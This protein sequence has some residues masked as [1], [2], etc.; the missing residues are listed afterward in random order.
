MPHSHQP[1][2]GPTQPVLSDLLAG[3]LRQ[4]ISRQAAGLASAANTGEV[5]PF[6]AATSQ[7]VDAKAAWSAA[8]AV[9]HYYHPAGKTQIWK[10]PA[11]WPALVSAQEPVAALAFSFGNYPQQVRDFHALLHAA[12]LTTLRP[13]GTG[14][15]VHVQFGKGAALGGNQQ[16]YPQALLNAGVVRLARQFEEAAELL[17][18]LQANIP[19]GWQAAWANEEAALAWHR[20]QAQE[21]KTLWLKQP[22]SVPILFNRGIAALF[23]G[24]PAEA[25]P[26]LS[27]AVEQLSAEDG[28]H[29]LGRLY[30]TLA[31]MR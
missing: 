11:E 29:H 16:G 6:E 4:E 19:A 14:P 10:V 12:D 30:L 15:A 3:Y 8:T 7:P 24:N 22:L 25:R 17:K 28:W 26:L 5:V 2:N 20:G 1:F 21:A 18:R 13:A 9:A 27:K 31:E 23:M